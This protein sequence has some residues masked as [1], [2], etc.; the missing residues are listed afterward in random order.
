L[1][2]ARDRR[3]HRLSILSSKT[4]H[5]RPRWFASVSERE[6][7]RCARAADGRARPLSALAAALTTFAAHALS[8]RK[9]AFALILTEPVDADTRRRV[10]PIGRRS[11][12][13]SA[14]RLAAAQAAGYV[15][16]SDIKVAAPALVGA[17]AEGLIGPLAPVTG[18]Q[19]QAGAMPVQTLTLSRCAPSVSPTREPALVVGRPVLPARA[20]R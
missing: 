17:F 14:K 20:L 7:G 9:L 10:S 11:P 19:L 18:D 6:I 13:K 15:L 1:R 4:D 16:R 12:A 8:G 5:H 3:R 2:S